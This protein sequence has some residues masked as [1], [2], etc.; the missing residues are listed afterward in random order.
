[1]TKYEFNN[2]VNAMNDIIKCDKTV[3]FNSYNAC[4]T[5]REI[6]AYDITKEH[7]G[8]AQYNDED[9]RIAKVIAYARFRGIPVPTIKEEPKFDRVKE[10]GGMTIGN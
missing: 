7:I 8:I 2:W 1:M 6:I 3:L 9:D 4:S 5:K 10:G